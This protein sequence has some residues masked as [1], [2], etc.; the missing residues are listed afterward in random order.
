M[1]RKI[2]MEKNK[3]QLTVIFR[4]VA[5]NTVVRPM[6]EA[7]CIA[8]G[9]E[10]VPYTDTCD[11]KEKKVSLSDLHHLTIQSNDD[12][13]QRLDAYQVALKARQTP[14]LVRVEANDV[15]VLVSKQTTLAQAMAIFK[16][17]IA[18]EYS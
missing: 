11:H 2:K 4:P 7:V 18:K 10:T 8:H 12:D 3:E 1:K 13:E 14:V 6:A 5:Q 16:Q 17:E 9:G 15:K